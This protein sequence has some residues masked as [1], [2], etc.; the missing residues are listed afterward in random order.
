MVRNG[1]DSKITQTN[2]IK[3]NFKKIFTISILASVLII[4]C[5]G[6]ALAITSITWTQNPSVPSPTVTPT[7]TPTPQADY[8]VKAGNKIITP[9]AD[10]TDYWIWDNTDKTF[11]MSISIKNVGDASGTPKITCQSLTDWSFSTSPTTI[12][13]IAPDQTLAVVLQIVYDGSG[14]PP[15][16]EVG[17]FTITV[18]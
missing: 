5:I 11:T 16:G 2:V 1:G 15:V 8:E 14:V 7:P 10:M 12:P 18:D 13:S 4:S 9:N 17:Q 3:P 6:L